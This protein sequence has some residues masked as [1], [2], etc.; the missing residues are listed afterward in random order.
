MKDAHVILAMWGYLWERGDQT[1]KYFAV[2]TIRDLKSFWSSVYHCR[3]IVNTNRHPSHQNIA[4]WDT[5]VSHGHIYLAPKWHSPS[6]DEIP[7]IF[8]G[9]RKA[10]AGIHRPTA[11]G[12]DSL[13]LANVYTDEPV[14]VKVYLLEQS[15]IRYRAKITWKN[16]CLTIR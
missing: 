6:S 4:T 10:P 5:C 7:I 13:L 9:V 15:Y 16:A 8:V 12:P 11:K 1:I 14:P 3:Y 2:P